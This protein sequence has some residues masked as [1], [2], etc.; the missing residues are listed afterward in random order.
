MKKYEPIVLDWINRYFDVTE[1][2]VVDAPF[3]PAG[4]MIKDDKGGT[5]LVYYDVWTEQVQYKF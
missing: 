1:I 3:M 4:K 5:M 2:E